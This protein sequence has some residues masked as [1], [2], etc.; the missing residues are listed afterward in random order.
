MVLE[1]NMRR[2]ARAELELER[3]AFKIFRPK[4]VVSQS[5]LVR[6]R[7]IRAWIGCSATVAAKAWMLLEDAGAQESLGSGASIDRFLMAMMMLKSYPT[8]IVG[9]SRAGCHEETFTHWAWAF[10]EELSYLEPTVVTMHL[11]VN[12]CYLLCDS[13]HCLAYSMMLIA[14]SLGESLGG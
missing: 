12:S 5:E 8:E 2:L 6:D 7:R 3:A 10:I 4:F 14:D 13:S 11:A 1:F 9:A